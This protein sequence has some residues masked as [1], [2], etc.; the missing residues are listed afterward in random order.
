MATGLLRFV[1]AGRAEASEGKLGTWLRPAAIDDVWPE[2]HDLRFDFP[3]TRRG[4]EWI[5]A[6]ARAARRALTSTTLG[7]VVGHL[8]WR[9][10]NLGFDSGRITAIYDWDS[11]SLVP[12]AALVGVTSVVHPVD[13]RHGLP[14][15][16]PSLGQ[17][18]GFVLDYERARGAPFSEP[19]REVLVAAQQWIASYGA[20][21]QHS[22]R[23][24]GFFPDVDH[25]KGWPRLLREL[26]DRR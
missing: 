23:I 9:V 4:A 2:P 5:D 22:D 19:E 20:R 7:S 1:T 13:W 25:T 12:E 14:D 16:L 10:Q 24:R 17:L 6:T 3:G 8:D 11:V 21:S 15:P 18:D 26:L